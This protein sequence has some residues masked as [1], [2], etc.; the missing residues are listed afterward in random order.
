MN[1][2]SLYILENVRKMNWHNTK[3]FVD[4]VDYDFCLSSNNSHFKIG[5]NTIAPGFDHFAEQGDERH[6]LFGRDLP[7]RPYPGSRI[8]DSLRGYFKLLNKCIRT[9]NGKYYGLFF[10]TLAKYLFVQVYIRIANLFDR[11]SRKGIQK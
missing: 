4:C 1:S 6:T 10:Q 7:M 11:G 8:R 2:G 9:G 3:F 5:E